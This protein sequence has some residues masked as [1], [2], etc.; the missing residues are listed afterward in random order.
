MA[1]P[2]LSE[3]LTDIKALLQ[4]TSWTDT[5]ITA[6][7]NRNLQKIAKGI[8][9][10]TDDGSVV[11]MLPLPDLYTI[12]TVTTS[13]SVP[14]VSLP[15]NY[16]RGLCYIERSAK[17]RVD[18]ADSFLEF[19]DDYPGLDRTHEVTEAAVKGS[20]LY[21]QGMP[22]TADTL[23]V[24]YYKKPSTMSASDDEPEGLPEELA[25][26]LLVYSTVKDYYLLIEDGMDGNTPNT[27]KYNSLFNG[28]LEDLEASIPVDGEPFSIFGNKS[29]RD[30]MYYRS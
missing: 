20:T 7:I 28:A 18:I 3:L 8:K 11:Q 17:I 13:T 5:Q 6:K 21:Y 16:Q 10:K 24:H 29:G 25:W 2:T 19:M 30:A 14:Y 15:S 9:K 26:D 12:G 22:S 27:V 23:T 4:D 1:A